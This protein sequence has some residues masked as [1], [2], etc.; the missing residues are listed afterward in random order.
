M[1]R[2]NLRNLIASTVVASGFCIGTP[3]QASAVPVNGQYVEDPRCDAIPTQ[4]L[5]HELGDQLIFP[6][7][8]SF[9]YTTGAVQFTVCVPNDGLANDW[10]VRMQNTSGVAWK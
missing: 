9:A 8:E 4:S 3:R 6:P 2:R 7:N 10:I 5:T 1:Q